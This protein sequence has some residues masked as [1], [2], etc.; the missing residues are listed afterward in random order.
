MSEKVLR[1]ALEWLRDFV[2][3]KVADFSI[4]HTDGV[5]M[6]DIIRKALAGDGEPEMMRL[7]R[8]IEEIRPQWEDNEYPNIV[9]GWVKNYIEREFGYTLEEE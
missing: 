3:T 5:E 1:A 4:S 6:M 8:W 9:L 2:D 7:L